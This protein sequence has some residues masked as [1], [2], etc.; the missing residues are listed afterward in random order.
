MLEPCYSTSA[1]F[2]WKRIPPEIK[3][4]NNE[5]SIIWQVGKLMWKKNYSEIY[6][7]INSCPAWPNHLKN[8]MNLILESTRRRVIALISRA[9]STIRLIE[10]SRLL[11][12]SADE[13]KQLATKHNWTYEEDTGFLL[14]KRD[15]NSQ[16]VKDGQVI[17]GLDRSTELLDKLGDYIVF[18]ENSSR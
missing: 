12:L 6:S 11:G 2:L 8:I 18:L 5:L 17:L 1:K 9:Y 15:N 14:I 7:A 13:T 10:A 4:A 16:M 3:T